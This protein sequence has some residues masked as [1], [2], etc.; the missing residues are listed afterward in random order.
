M[1]VWQKE[2]ADA[3]EAALR[4]AE[5]HSSQ[6]SARGYA[7]Q[8]SGG[9][10]SIQRILQDCP[11][12]WA[13]AS[14]LN[15]LQTDAFLTRVIALVYANAD[16][17]KVRLFVTGDAGTGKS[18]VMRAFAL[19]IEHLEAAVGYRRVVPT[20]TAAANVN[21]MTIASF[22]G[23]GRGQKSGDADEAIPLTTS[24]ASITPEVRSRLE[25]VEVVDIDEISMIGH[26]SLKR[27]HDR[28]GQVHETGKGEPFG[29]RIVFA[30][31]K[32]LA[33]QSAIKAHLPQVICISS[34][35][36]PTQR[37]TSQH[38]ASATYG[39]P[40]AMLFG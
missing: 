28:L 5:Q 1:G 3:E 7:V 14:T 17:S 34:P 26:Q 32:R 12:D 15:K 30:T 16:G 11:V 23:F 10:V 36:L 40:S 20:G 6:P 22:F 33:G 2:Q 9:L 13:R 39:I 38:R 29:N 24:E 8:N 37:C 27:I 35:R 19:Y 18:V 25:P 31:G 21:G 4:H